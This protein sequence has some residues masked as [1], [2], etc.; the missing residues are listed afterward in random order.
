[1]GDPSSLQ[2]CRTGSIIG[3]VRASLFGVG[4]CGICIRDAMPIIAAVVVPLN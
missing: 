1:M 4:T 2:V 3:I